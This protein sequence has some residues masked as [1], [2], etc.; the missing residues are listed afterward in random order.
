MKEKVKMAVIVL[1]MVAL[2]IYGVLTIA[3]PALADDASCK[4]GNCKCSCSGTDCACAA[5]GGSCACEC[6]TGGSSSCEPQK[7]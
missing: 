4:S 5:T 2:V 7:S 3:P 1:W 6:A